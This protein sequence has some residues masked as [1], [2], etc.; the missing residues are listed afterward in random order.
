MIEQAPDGYNIH[1]NNRFYHLTEQ[2]LEDMWR[3]QVKPRRATVDGRTIP[4]DAEKEWNLL[5]YAFKSGDTP[6][7][8][9]DL[10]QQFT[11]TR[12][13]NRQDRKNLGLKTVTKDGDEDLR[14]VQNGAPVRPWN[15]A[16]KPK[17]EGFDEFIRRQRANRD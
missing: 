15:A 6:E 16:T 3:H 1:H 7:R 9:L 4:A 8:I 5:Y 17:Q 10:F 2:W 14:A 11:D 12:T 13:K